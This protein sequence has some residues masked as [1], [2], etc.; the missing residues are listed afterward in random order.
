MT[1]TRL[2]IIADDRFV[3]VDDRGLFLPDLSWIPSDFSALQWTGSSGEIEFRDNRPNEEITDLGIYSR[4]VTDHAAEVA[5]L[6]AAEEAK[7]AARDYWEEFRVIRNYRIS[8]TDWTQLQDSP[9]TDEERSNWQ[10]YRTQ[11]RDLPENIS[12][13]RALVHDPSHA[14]WPVSPY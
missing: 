8:I 6:E 1:F 10:T 5:R 14:D 13:P 3:S 9:I 12:D 2:T 7:E 4:A 11:L